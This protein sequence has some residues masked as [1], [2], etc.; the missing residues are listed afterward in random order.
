MPRVMAEKYFKGKGLRSIQGKP[1][2]V[3][4]MEAGAE[5][6][7]F[8]YR[9]TSGNAP[10]YCLVLYPKPG[11]SWQE[12]VS[13]ITGVSPDQLKP[14]GNVTV[15]G[16]ALPILLDERQTIIRLGACPNPLP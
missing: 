4:A 9:E 6:Y 8:F 13:R 12:A 3:L 11:I 15:S 2:E 7:L 1:R 10:P 16:I 5:R 14:A